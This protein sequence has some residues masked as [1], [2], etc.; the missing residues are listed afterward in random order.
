MHFSRRSG[1]FEE[2]I[3]SKRAPIF[4]A[5][6]RDKSDERG[7]FRE[8]ALWFLVKTHHGI[9]FLRKVR[10]HITHGGSGMHLGDWFWFVFG[11]ANGYAH[12]ALAV[13]AQHFGS[14]E[15]CIRCR[16]QFFLGETRAN[17]RYLSCDLARTIDCYDNSLLGDI[18]FILLSVHS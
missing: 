4:R 9:P 1:I 14:K 17:E 11:A 7:S 6:S 16:E 12:Q 18:F 2:Y 13:T 3:V 8:A 15:I 10:F 5:T